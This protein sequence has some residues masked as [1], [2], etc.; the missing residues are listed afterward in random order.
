MHK[1]V[2]LKIAGIWL[3]DP[4]RIIFFPGLISSWPYPHRSGDF[5][6]T[7]SGHVVYR[8]LYPLSYLLMFRHEACSNKLFSSLHQRHG[9]HRLPS[10]DLLADD[11]LG[12]HEMTETSG[13]YLYF[14]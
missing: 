5:D 11:D 6:D 7:S 4:V 3:V 2:F 9:A 14:K 12:G 8:P 1:L 13:K 10:D